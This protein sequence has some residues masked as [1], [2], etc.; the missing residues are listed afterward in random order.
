MEY[1][2]IREEVVEVTHKKDIIE[3]SGKR[4]TYNNNM[5]EYLQEGKLQRIYESETDIFTLNVNGNVV[6]IEKK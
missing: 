3:L 6:K 2:D 5:N 4:I 1:K